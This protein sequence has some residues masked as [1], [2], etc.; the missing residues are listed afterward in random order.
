MKGICQHYWQGS[1]LLVFETKTSVKLLSKLLKGVPLI[2]RERNQLT[3]TLS[4]LFKL[5]PF[6]IIVIVPFLEFALP[7]LL[8]FFP[9]MLPSTFDDISKRDLKLELLAKA[10]AQKA[11]IFQEALKLSMKEGHQMEKESKDIID[12]LQHLPFKQEEMKAEEKENHLKMIDISSFYELLFHSNLQISLD[13]LSSES[14]RQLCLFM[15]IKTFGSDGFLRY[16]LQRKFDK[17]KSDD[18][19]IKAEGVSN[20]E[21][22][23]LRQLCVERGIWIANKNNDDL[24]K[25]LEE[26]VH[27]HIDKRIPTLSMFLVRIMFNNQKEVK[28]L[29][30]E[31]RLNLM[32]GASDKNKY[33]FLKKEEKLISNELKEGK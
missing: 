17:I 25:E 20:L 9:N 18:I 6:I 26:W 10:K 30:E 16:L 32:S 13:Y 22:S 7:L 8:K 19:D 23:D 28:P 11:K 5:I 29:M 4:D 14:I 21:L 12:F 3:R 27:Y 15:S 33:D 24:V 1:K 2:R 31:V